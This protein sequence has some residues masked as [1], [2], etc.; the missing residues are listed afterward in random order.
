MALAR[1]CA[2]SAQGRHDKTQ[3][4][5]A[6]GDKPL[7]HAQERL[8]LSMPSR[9]K[10]RTCIHLG[11]AVL[12]QEGCIVLFQ[13]VVHALDLC[14]ALFDMSGGSDDPLFAGL[15]AAVVIV[16]TALGLLCRFDKEFGLDLLHPAP[17]ILDNC[18]EVIHMR[19]DA[20]A[21]A[22]IRS[23]VWPNIAIVTGGFKTHLLQMISKAGPPTLCAGC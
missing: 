22:A 19:A 4:K 20:V 13:C 11:V 1:T 3:V 23:M 7:P 2:K 14:N 8:V 10:E 17:G 5:A 15:V 12:G 9:I 6:N 18:L 16:Q 21:T